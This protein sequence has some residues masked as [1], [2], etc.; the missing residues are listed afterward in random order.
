MTAEDRLALARHRMVER[1]IRARG[2]RDPRVLE[3]MES[4]PREC[5][6]APGTESEAFEDHP[7]PIGLGQTLSQPYIVAYMTEEARI[8]PADR[9]LE[10]GTGSG[11][12]AAILS[13]VA[14]A[15][16]TVECLPAHA[17]AAAARLARLGFGNVF[18]REGD[19]RRGWPE[20]APFD[21]VLVTAAA[22]SV[23]PDLL[24]QLA[25]GGRMIIPLG[26]VYGAQSLYRFRRTA[27]GAVQREPLIGVRF[28]PLVTPPDPCPGE[29]G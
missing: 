8:R 11:Y 18:C 14:A 15:V 7:L 23:P 24:E 28:V 2:V 5:F 27:D 9:V 10:I 21:A 19:G 22:E 3:A 26:G 17:R 4:V 13:R 29:G 1:Q 6:T 12:Q 20:Q 25:P 16:Y